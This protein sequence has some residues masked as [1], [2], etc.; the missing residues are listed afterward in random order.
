MKL[1]ICRS[2]VL[3]AAVSLNIVSVL[4]GS[5]QQDTRAGASQA[6]SMLSDAER[7]VVTTVRRS[8]YATTLI[9]TRRFVARPPRVSLG[10]TGFSSP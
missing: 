6:T 10:A 7:R 4:A 8:S 3:C 1:F 9:S 2:L 5:Q